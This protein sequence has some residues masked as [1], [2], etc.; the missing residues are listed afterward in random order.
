MA[1]VESGPMIEMATG[2]SGTAEPA[3]RSHDI[4]SERFRTVLDEAKRHLGGYNG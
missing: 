3:Q 1:E 2:A 4:Q